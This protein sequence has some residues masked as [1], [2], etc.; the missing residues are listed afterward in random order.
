MKYIVDIDGTIC[1][2]D[3]PD[4]PYEEAAPIKERIHFFN[5]LFD[6]GHEVIYWTAR[7]GN[8]GV[9]HSQLTKKQLNDWGVKRTQLKMG[10]PPYD[11]WID[12]KA[13]NVQDFFMTDIRS[14]ETSSMTL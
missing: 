6:A 5:Q 12:D 10:K 4:T 3:S 2:H 14:G 8:S 1:T 7:G 13:F 9:D 11:Y